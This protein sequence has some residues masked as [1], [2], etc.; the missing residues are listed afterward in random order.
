YSVPCAPDTT[1]STG[2]GRLPCT[3]TTP[4]EYPES[5]PAGTTM[6]PYAFS[7]RRA[8]A[9][10]TVIV[11]CGSGFWANRASGASKAIGASRRRITTSRRGGSARCYCRQP[12]PARPVQP[13][14]FPSRTF[15]ADFDPSLTLNPD[16]SC[17]ALS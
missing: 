15:G 17:A 11:A 10:P 14:G 2:P 1:A 8:V 9:V 13:G 3:T 12:D 16:L 6:A 7:P 5:T 4:I